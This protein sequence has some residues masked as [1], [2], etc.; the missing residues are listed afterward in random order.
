MFF[1]NICCYLRDQYCSW[2]ETNILVTICLFFASFHYPQLF[3]APAA[4]QASLCTNELSIPIPHVSPIKPATHS[5]LHEFTP[6]TQVPPFSH[7]LDA[8][9][10]ISATTET[11]LQSLRS[12]GYFYPAYVEI[13]VCLTFVSHTR[14]VLH[15]KSYYPAPGPQPGGAAG[16]FPP[17]NFQKH[18]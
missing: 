14:T 6:S 18:I 8:H 17:R 10:S 13:Y 3:T 7:G 11:N 1:R 15:Q 2:T 12:N 4:V 16:Q 5:Q 9:S